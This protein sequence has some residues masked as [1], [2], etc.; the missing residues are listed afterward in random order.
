LVHKYAHEEW[1]SG[2]PVPYNEARVFNPKENGKD[3]FCY[4]NE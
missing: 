2:L 4:G 3:V 1:Y